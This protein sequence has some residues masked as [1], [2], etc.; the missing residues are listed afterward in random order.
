M[1]YANLDI[2]NKITPREICILNV[3]IASVQKTI[4]AQWF[5]LIFNMFQE[6]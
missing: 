3:F 4:T 6:N 1:F 2:G 5:Q